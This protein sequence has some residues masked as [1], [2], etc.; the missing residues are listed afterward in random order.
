MYQT[1]DVWACKL[2]CGDVVHGRYIV[3]VS[4]VGDSVTFWTNPM[5][6][7]TGRTV[8]AFSKLTVDRRVFRREE[9]A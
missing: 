6:D 1:L 8:H 4:Q 5:Y 7:K 9:V 2:R 3:R